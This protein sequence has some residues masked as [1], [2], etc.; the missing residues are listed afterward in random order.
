MNTVLGKF[1]SPSVIGYAIMMFD[2]DLVNL[3][4]IFI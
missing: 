1:A 4:T 2:N 3:F